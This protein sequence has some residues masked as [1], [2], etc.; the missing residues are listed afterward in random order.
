MN[1][2]TKDNALNLLMRD[3]KVDIMTNIKI[4]LV[5]LKN[6][7]IA[8]SKETEAIQKLANKISV[9][10]NTEACNDAEQV[11]Y[12]AKNQIKEAKNSFSPVASDISKIHKVF[13]GHRAELIK[14][15]EKISDEMSRKIMAYKKGQERINQ[16]RITKAKAEEE[17]LRKEAEEKQLQDAIKAEEMGESKQVVDEIADVEVKIEVKPDIIAVPVLDVRQFKKKWD[18]RVIDK[19]KIPRAHLKVDESGIK[20]FI[21]WSKGEVEIPGIEIYEVK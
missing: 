5:E 1:S 3:D 4:K 12:A 8:I 9:I 16:E 2:N 18:F 20:Q 17:R 14:P 15:L 13:T 7:S 10:E 6:S 21:R 19:S 11:F